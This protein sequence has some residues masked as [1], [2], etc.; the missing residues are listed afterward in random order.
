MTS[1]RHAV[2][3]ALAGSLM[4]AAGCTT[5]PEVKPDPT[6]VV[7]PVKKVEKSE[8]E[9]FADGV[10]AMDAKKY[11]EAAEVFTAYAEKNANDPNARFNLGLALERQLKIQEA[12]KA[13]EAALQIDP[14]HEPSLLNL[15]RI[16]RLQDKF[17]EAIALY[18]K[19]LAQP[20]KEYDVQL[21]NNLSVSYRLAK[22][23]V[24]AEAA[25]RKILS[26]TKDDVDAYK[27]LSLIYFDQG[28]YRLAE[29]IS[30]TA[31]KFEQEA[32]KK[33]PK[34]KS[35]PG[36][37]N[38][39]GMI[40]LKMGDKARALAQFQRAVEL[41]PNFAAARMNLG[42]MALAYRDYSKA[43]S[44]FEQAVKLDPTSYEA[45][46]YYGY[47]LDGQKGREP[48]KGIAAA[49]QFEKVLEFKPEHSEA[50]CSAG[51][52]YAVDKSGWQK[53]LGFLQRCKAF[54]TDATQLALLDS[55]VKG[56]EAL[57]KS[58]Q[59]REAQQ[60]EQ[61]KKEAAKPTGPSLLDKVSNDAAA[62]EAAEAP[63]AEGQAPAEG[64]EGSGGSTETAPPPAD[65]AK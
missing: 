60:A 30:G 47:A 13:Y 21:L 8:A 24:K 33:N 9:K 62:Q 61:Q 65:A 35:D 49:A 12:Q 39:L 43:E 26:R 1:I 41:D 56:L 31:L 50:V 34:L 58:G 44:S 40:Y 54:T 27:N 17:K 51:W 42:A 32:Q 55:K 16:Y 64:A 7:A 15:G 4:L 23:Y 2:V 52:A 48:K 5:T 29:F 45:Y 20:D 25:V 37:P 36:I 3:G 57:I 19:A 18:E 11:A 28:N 59:Q 22:D 6:P 14:Q 38:N 53:A 46:L 10:A 63:P